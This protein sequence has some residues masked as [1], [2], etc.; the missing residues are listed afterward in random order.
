MFHNRIYRSLSNGHSIPKFAVIV[1]FLFLS[2]FSSYAIGTDLLPNFLGVVLCTLIV[3]YLQCIFTFMNF[4]HVKM[5]LT[6]WVYRV[7]IKE[8][9]TAVFVFERKG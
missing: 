8:I 2:I 6:Y 5:S 4:F 7:L 9:F 1:P 3:L